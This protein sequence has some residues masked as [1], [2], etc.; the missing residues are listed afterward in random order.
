MYNNDQIGQNDQIDQIVLNDQN[1]PKGTKMY[2]NDQ[3]DQ[4]GQMTKI[5]QN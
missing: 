3:I 1:G 4:N 2:K 5:D